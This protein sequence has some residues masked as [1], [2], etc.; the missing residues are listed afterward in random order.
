MATS[1][2]ARNATPDGGADGRR[3]LVTG[4]TKVEA[5]DLLDWLENHGCRDATLALH[6]EMFAVSMVPPLPEATKDMPA[7][8]RV[9]A[10]ASCT[11]S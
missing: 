7:R 5:E 11:P 9:V 1:E 10:S 3:V 4:L 6:G 2:S 8:H